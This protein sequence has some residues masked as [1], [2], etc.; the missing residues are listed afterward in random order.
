LIV[1][2]GEL[3]KALRLRGAGQVAQEALVLLSSHLEDLAERFAG[4]CV[5]ALEERNA[6]RDV[7]RIPLLKRLTTADVER[8][9]GRSNGKS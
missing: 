6:A 1:R 7:Q 4:E 3:G 8:A 9:I 2:V 5:R